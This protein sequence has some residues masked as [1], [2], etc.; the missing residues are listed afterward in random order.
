[1]ASE[2]EG[3]NSVQAWTAKRAALNTTGV[4]LLMSALSVFTGVLAARLLGPK[5]RGELVAIQAWPSALASLALLGTSQAVLYFCAKEPQKRSSYLSAALLVGAA[6]A[7][8]FSVIGFVAMPR[9]LASQSSAVV[10]G[11]RI[12]LFQIWMYLFI[13]MPT[14]ILRSSGRFAA[15]N[16]LRLCPMIIWVAIFAVAW[17]VGERSALPIASAYIVLGWLILMPQL[18]IL[19]REG[20]CLTMPR[21]QEIRDILR[22]GLPA[23]GTFI[24]RMLN[25]R[26]DQILMAGFLPPAALGQY[27]A[28]VA[29]SG[30]GTFLM[31]GVSSVIVPKLAALRGSGRCAGGPELARATRSCVL[32]AVLTATG[33][34]LFASVGIPLFFG[35]RFTPAIRTARLLAAAGGVAGLNL[36]L[37]EGMCGLA[38]PVSVLRAES[39]GVVVTLGG[40]WLLLRPMGIYGAAVVSMLSYAVT[41]CWLLAE[42]RFITRVSPMDFLIPRRADLMLFARAVREV[43]SSGLSP[44][45]STLRRPVDEAS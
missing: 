4:N 32:M 21:W 15:W 43:V 34:L 28:A 16:L 26:L 33:L 44:L 41:S 18:F 9:L 11:A 14:E 8:I 24:P 5:G 13:A 39:V 35:S 31:H 12:F 7:L 45:I 1:M 38:R 36:V 3:E 23:V 37:S 40:L 27:A 10:W 42:A 6:G 25:L 20:L 17:L 22:F 19:R 29:W 30:A 2:A